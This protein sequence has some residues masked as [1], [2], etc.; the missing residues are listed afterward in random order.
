MNNEKAKR[1]IGELADLFG[2]ALV[3]NEESKSLDVL[4]SHGKTPYEAGGGTKRL[5]E[6]YGE[7]KTRTIVNRAI[8]AEI[9]GGDGVLNARTILHKQGI[10]GDAVAELDKALFDMENEI[11]RR[12]GMNQIE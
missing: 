10:Q 7:G 8:R 3:T 1:L 5:K 11:R 6:T 9:P 4:V 2:C 12:F